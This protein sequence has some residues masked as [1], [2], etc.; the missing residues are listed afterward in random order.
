MSIRTILLQGVRWTGLA[1]A[2]NL[3][4]G[5]LQ[6]AILARLLTPEDF[7]WVAIAAVF[8]NLGLHLQNT[9]VNTAII[10][11]PNITFSAFSTL[12][13]LNI[14]TGFLLFVIFIII[15]LLISWFYFSRTLFW[16]TFTYSF[17]YLINAISVQ[18]KALL[19]KN[20]Q[21]GRYALAEIIGSVGAF[22]FAIWAAI[23]GWGAFALVGGYL[24]R[25]ILEGI[26][27]AAYGFQQA[28][29]Q[30][31]WDW[32]AA[33][34][35]VIFGSNHL[36]ERIFTNLASQID[37]LLIGKLL[38]SEAL[39]IYDVIKR[40][41]I[42]PL[43]LLNDIFE[44]ITF[45]IFSRYQ[46]DIP[47]QR[48]IFHALIA[49]LAAINFPILLFIISIAKPFLLFFLGTKWLNTD[50]VLQ[51]MCLFCI[52]HFLLNPIDTLLASK[53]KIT[54]WLF[55]NILFLPAVIITLLIGSYF[56]LISAIIGYVIIHFLFI[57][58]IYFWIVIPT[59]Q[60]SA[61]ELLKQI[62]TPFLLSIFDA[63]LIRL[64]L[65]YFIFWQL[66]LIFGFIY[67]LLTWL[68]NR[69]IIFSLLGLL[70]IDK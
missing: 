68:F 18:Y 13:W 14:L 21:F 67:I 23:N 4:L 25:S 12:Y 40:I 38:G 48:S 60:S 46:N 50:I 1:A 15:S 34:P 2:C 42:R 63:I 61:K 33:K 66:G 7:A 5:L 11:Q 8:I 69:K 45:P 24:M 57:I 59:I 49:H 37:V 28:K 30:L 9:G 65:P 58:I 3:A 6:V 62:T 29:P 44:K 31:I 56:G 10:Q 32:E 27:I 35:F 54:T 16:V 19:Q 36:S 53:N 39:G 52:A 55:A 26:C 22:L 41:L 20:L 17:I 64:L 43:Y 70:K 51:W 47:V